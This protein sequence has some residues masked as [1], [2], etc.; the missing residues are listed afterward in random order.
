[1]RKALLA[2]L[3]VLA[4]GTAYAVTPFV[5]AWQIRE[6]IRAGDVATLRER[7][8]WQNVRHT[9]KSSLAEARLVVTEITQ[10][11]GV[12]KPGLWQRAK[13]A[14]LPYLSDPLIDRYVSAEGAPRLYQLRQTWR[15]QVKPTLG[16][17]ERPTL[18]AGTWLAGTSLDRAATLLRRVEAARFVSPHRFELEVA[19]TS[20]PGRRWL[21]ALEFRGLSWL[22]TEMHVLKGPGRGPAGRLAGL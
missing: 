15:R 1:M 21:A 16:L 14:A 11:A 17:A 2:A 22:L 6:A 4:A 10:A 5:A 13:A 3:L 12:A 9:L 20:R 18:L 8:D 19:D 7:V